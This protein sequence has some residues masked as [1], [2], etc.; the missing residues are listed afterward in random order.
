PMGPEV[1]GNAAVVS[2]AG[3]ISIRHE[4]SMDPMFPGQNPSRV[5]VTVPGGQFDALVLS[6]WGEPDYPPSR[7]E[8]IG[9]FRSLA[10]GRLPDHQTEAIIAAVQ[11]L[12]L[13]SVGPLLEALQ[14]RSR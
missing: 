12:R 6:P 11:A 10:E 1:L 8:L 13:G 7:A 4:A 14:T 3:K 5:I 2:L 9:K